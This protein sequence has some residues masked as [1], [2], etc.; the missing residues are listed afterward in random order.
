M[1]DKEE[2]I[3]KQIASSVNKNATTAISAVGNL[4]KQNTYDVAGNSKEKDVKKDV[5]KDV[6]FT[7][8]VKSGVK[9]GDLPTVEGD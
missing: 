3:L 9:I 5:K 1:V 8:G 6:T 4:V 2:K 7:G